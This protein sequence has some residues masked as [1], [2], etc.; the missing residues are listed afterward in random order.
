[1]EEI[2]KILGT[3]KLI[4]GKEKTM[5]AL[6]KGLVKKV[7]LAKNAPQDLKE[8]IDYYKE[9]SDVSVENTTLSN[10]E[11]GTLCKKSFSISVLAIL[12]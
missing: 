4:I 5:K 9:L 12:K 6:S 2:K 10:E 7:L 8:D 1:M 3:D 11:L